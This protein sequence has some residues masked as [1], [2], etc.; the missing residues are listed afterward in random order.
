[1]GFVVVL[2]FE[3]VAA[4]AYAK[5]INCMTNISALVVFV[6]QGNYLLEIAVLMSVFNVAGS[7]IGSKIALKNGNGFVRIIFLVIVSL[8][9][10]RY[11]YDVF[12]GN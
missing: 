3:F 1:L 5:I 9:I 11:G 12:Y 7:L 8:M 6:H 4:S 10:L 2:G